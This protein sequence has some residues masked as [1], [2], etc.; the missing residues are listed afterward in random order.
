VTWLT[1]RIDE[2]LKSKLKEVA[3]L[4]RVQV[5]DIVRELI[6]KELGRLSFL[7]DREKKA[8]GLMQAEKP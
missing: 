3:R 7:S 4:R 8:L 1:I 5:S 6:V 2:D